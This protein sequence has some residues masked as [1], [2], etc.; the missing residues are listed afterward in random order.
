[1][2]AAMKQKSTRF[3]TVVLIFTMLLMAPA[4]AAAVKETPD[5]NALVRVG[6]YYGS[7]VAPSF[8]LQNVTDKGTGYRLGY[9]DDA[10]QFVQLGYTDKVKVSVLRTI[11]LHYSSDSNSYTTSETGEGTVGCYHIQIPGEF[12]DFESAK[13]VADSYGGFVAWI[14]GRYLVRIGSYTSYSAAESAAAVYEG[15]SVGETSKYGLSLVATGTTNILFQFDDL[16][17]GTGFGVKPGL[18]D[19]IKTQ[20]WCKGYRYFG[21]FRYQRI[22]GSDIT[23]V[24]L[25]EMNDYINCVI[26]REMSESWPVEAL[27]A[28]AICARNYYA[29]NRGKHKAYGFDIC[30][31]V[32]CQAY[33]GSSRIGSNTTQAAEETAGE[34][35]W[36]G[37]ELAATYYYASNGGTTESSENVWGKAI[38]YLRGVV[39]PYEAFVADKVSNYEWSYTFT[40]V[41]LQ[42]KLI[43]SGR[44]SCGVITSVSLTST[45]LG[46]VLSMTFHDN[47]GKDWTIYRESCRTVLGMRSMRFGLDRGPGIPG[48]TA[49]IGN[50]YVNNNESMDLSQG[51]YAVDAL[52]SVVE[53][54]GPAHVLTATGVSPLEGAN[55]ANVCGSTQTVS[56]DTFVF[57]GSGWGHNIGMSQW[58]AY[59]MAKQGLTYQDILT[60]YYTDVTIKKTEIVE[61]TPEVPDVNVPTEE[62][63][64]ENPDV[65]IPTE[66]DIT[67]VED[68]E[69][70]Y[71]DT[72]N[73]GTENAD[74]N[75]SG[76]EADGG[77]A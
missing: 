56:G 16:G 23:L 11:S 6:L 28:Q 39:D 73:A 62:G 35:L 58:G 65:N 50:L 66:E 38:P 69:T 19:D 44:T 63:N 61:E 31:A 1:M 51:I 33:Y 37:D 75:T 5:E 74:T 15:A 10:L 68:P 2:L 70:E 29:V 8:N 32:H 49:V 59:A 48:E 22:T 64:I 21:S 25:V 72:G 47:K 67:E 55:F 54:T 13:A 24:N 53:I 26:S 18:T 20:T 9:F 36:Y 30:N 43:A 57:K 42:K 17:E 52:G 12:T 76:G 40:G 4:Q 3:L 60:F 14:G 45:E 71:T 46:N 41:E 7:S 77:N 27:K 34:Y